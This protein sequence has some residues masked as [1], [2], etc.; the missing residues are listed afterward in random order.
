[1]ETPEDLYQKYL[2]HSVSLPD[3]DTSCP[4]QLP[5]KYLSALEDKLRRR[6][7]SA[8]S[9]RMLYLSVFHTKPK[10]LQ[11]LHE[12]CNVAVK[13][14]TQMEKY[15]EHWRQFLQLH[16]PGHK[17]TKSASFV[18]ISQQNAQNEDILEALHQHY[19]QPQ[20]VLSE[21]FLSG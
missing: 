17:T 5:H 15:I 8:D 10:Q 1:M 9:S 7:T 13:C 11:G 2:N 14:F 20:P 3:N 18:I 16:Q 19:Q 6:V 21:I 12:F 4:L